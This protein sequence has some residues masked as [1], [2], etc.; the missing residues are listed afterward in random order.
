MSSGIRR[1]HSHLITAIRRFAELES[2]VVL[3]PERYDPRRQTGLDGLR[4]LRDVVVVPSETVTERHQSPVGFVV[5]NTGDASQGFITAHAKAALSSEIG[6]AKKALRAGDVIISRLR[7]Y[8]CQVAYLDPGF[9]ADVPAGADVVCSTEFYVLR[10]PDSASI[11][12]LVPYL[13]SPAVQTVLAAAQE[14]GHHP[15]FNLTT[16]LELPIPEEM[17]E[18]REV[19]SGIVEEAT[20]AFRVAVHQMAGLTGQTLT[21]SV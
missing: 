1:W 5:L 4:R 16:L 9:W 12:F 3:A 7:P 19:I 6:S 8:L 13:L 11:S 14:G 21:K 18:R 2:G 17:H 15:R 20:S 10:S